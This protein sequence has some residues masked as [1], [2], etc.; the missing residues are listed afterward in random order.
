MCWT[1]NVGAMQRTLVWE[2]RLNKLVWGEISSRQSHVKEYWSNEMY[3]DVGDIKCTLMWEKRNMGE[4]RCSQVNGRKE[5][6]SQIHRVFLSCQGG[7]QRTPKE[8]RMEFW[9]YVLLHP[10]VDHYIDIYRYI[11]SNK[12]SDDSDGNNHDSDKNENFGKTFVDLGSLRCTDAR[13]HPTSGRDWGIQIPM[14]MLMMIM[15]RSIMI[16][17]MKT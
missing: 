10:W 2:K 4:M 6:L 11:K 9:E 17:M 12:S 3:F 1:I 8:A 14:M 15:V 7:G 13:M 16:V 5:R